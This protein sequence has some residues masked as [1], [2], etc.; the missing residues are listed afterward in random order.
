MKSGYGQ[1][2]DRGAKYVHRVSYENAK[3]PVPPGLQVLHHC[4]NRKCVN[5]DH[6]F[7][8]TLKDNMEDMVSKRRQA[9]GPRCFH[10]RLTVEQVHAIR[11][12]DEK[13]QVIADQYGVTNSLVSL[14]KARKIWRYV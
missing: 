2:N 5:P 7:V 1:I 14:I 9:H 13:Q 3:G 6:L 11:A 4:D 12:S 8:G 10:A